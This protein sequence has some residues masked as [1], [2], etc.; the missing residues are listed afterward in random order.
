MAVRGLQRHEPRVDTVAFEAMREPAVRLARRHSE[1]PAVSLQCVEQVEHALKQRLLDLAGRAKVLERAAIVVGKLQVALRRLIWK[2][3]RHRFGEVKTDD[4]PRHLRRRYLN[5][6]AFEAGLQGGMDRRAT[7]DE[8]SV[9]VEDRKPFHGHLTLLCD[10][11]AR[12]SPRRSRRRD[13]AA[14]AVLRGGPA[15][16]RR[17][18]TDSASPALCSKPSIA[19][20]SLK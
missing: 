7:V 15:A 11:R 14:A 3:R 17:C 4:T 19:R 6:I 2:K 5:A 8:R 9:A 10:P 20:L 16:G 12:R 1:Q 18:S 13:F